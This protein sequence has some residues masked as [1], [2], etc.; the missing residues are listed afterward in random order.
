MIRSVILGACLL[1]ITPAGIRACTCTKAAPGVC[2]GLQSD[3][4]VF[5]GTV[6]DAETL[7]PE[8]SDATP[9]ETAGGAAASAT[10]PIT[11]YHFRIDEHF[12]GPDAAE[13]DIFSGG[14]DGDCGY[15]FKKGD[16]YLVFTQQETEGRLFATICNG[17]RPASE[18]RAILPQLRAMKNGQHVASVFGMIR[19]SDPPLLAPTDDPEDPLSH[20]ALRLRSKFDRFSTAT[21]SNGVYSFY[22]VHAGNYA[23]TA[24]LPASLELTQRT[25][26]GALPPVRIPGGACYEFNIVGL[27]TGRI[28][29]SVLGADGKPLH[30]ASVELYRSDQYSDARPGL[31]TFQ[32]EKGTFEFTHIGPG[33]YIL[34]F[35]RLDRMDP[36]TP[37]PRTFYPSAKDASETKLIR[38]KDGQDVQKV[39]IK[40]AEAYP[41]RKIRVQLK[42]TDGRIPGDVYALAKADQGDNPAAQ[43]IGDGEYEFTLLK[44]ANY[45][46]TAGEDPDPGHP[47]S[48]A[49]KGDCGV[50]A[51][52]DT[53]PVTVSGADEDTKNIVLK[54]PAVTCEAGPPPPAQE[55]ENNGSEGGSNPPPPS[56][57]SNQ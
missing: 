55:P 44:S 9:P 57:E 30:L 3:D 10:T 4:V 16:Q 18:D 39:N 54:F 13:I 32:G 36:N 26:N 11:R 25:V 41:T 12:A 28:R 47:G 33:E 52:I 35:N 24:N 17:T 22:D 56:P 43:V 21:D 45:V 19:R 23:L 50:P 51:H 5:L 14:D 34:V 48:H 37:Y 27:P 40:L 2:P 8:N 53:P 42:W 15:N 7:A 38:V 1:L 6:T 46:F 31:W 20:V 49:G 29:G